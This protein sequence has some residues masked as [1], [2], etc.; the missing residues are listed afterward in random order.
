MAEEDLLSVHDEVAIL[1]VL[2]AQAMVFLLEHAS[3][4]DQAQAGLMLGQM[5]TAIA[6]IKS[7]TER[8]LLG[9]TT[10]EG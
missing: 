10:S 1:A 2:T 4:D 6:R 3:I 8:K 9:Q 5:N 7:V